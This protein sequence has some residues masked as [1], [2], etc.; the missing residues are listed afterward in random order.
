MDVVVHFGEMPF[1]NP[2]SLYWMPMPYQPNASKESRLLDTNEK[3][4]R[5]MF[6][7]WQGDLPLIIASD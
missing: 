1:N 4:I 5:T 7:T 3:R 6:L 2:S